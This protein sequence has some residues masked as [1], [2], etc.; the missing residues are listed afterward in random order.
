MMGEETRRRTMAIV[1]SEPK[2]RVRNPATIRVLICLLCSI[3][4]H[5][6]G[7]DDEA[8]RITVVALDGQDL[9]NDS[10]T[11]FALNMDDKIDRLTNLGLGVA[12]GAL[13]VAAHHEIGKTVQCFF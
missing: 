6:S 8:L 2:D 13:R 10:A 3:V 5:Q 9:A 12:K 4:H 1:S 11:G 7:F